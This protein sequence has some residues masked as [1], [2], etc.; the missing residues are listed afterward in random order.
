MKKAWLYTALGVVVFASGLGSGVGWASG[1]LPQVT[2]D[3]VPF[4][5]KAGDKQ[6]S[7]VDGYNDG[8]QALPGSMNYKG[9][10]YIPIRLVAETLGYEVDWDDASKTAS[11]LDPSKSDDPVSDVPDAPAKT[12]YAA[13][14]A[15]LTSS[16]VLLDKAN[17]SGTVLETLA[18]GT[19]VSVTAEASREY[20]AV[21]VNGR[22]GYVASSS[23]D[24]RY[25]ADRPAWERKADTIIAAG[26]KFMGAPYEF[27]ASTKQT[28]TFD[29][30]SFTKHIFGLSG[31]TLPRDSRQQS[32][33]GQDVDISQLRK[34]DLIFFTTPQRKNAVGLQRIG[35]VGVYLGDNKVLHTYRVGIGVTVTELDA[36]WTKRIISA[37]REI[38]G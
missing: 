18:S 36:N 12:E 26:M 8:T 30:S 2:A 16:T 27:G 25:K 10:T 22:Q 28:N 23:A 9:T 34:G 29:C 14:S 11:I 15:V 31:I 13:N 5:W 33:V 32:Q 6:F 3:L 19:Q 4:F 17:A 20:L 38:Q 7:A 35:H 1:K 24:Y 37:K 21:T